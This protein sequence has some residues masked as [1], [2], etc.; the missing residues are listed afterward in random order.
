MLADHYFMKLRKIVNLSISEFVKTIKINKA[1]VLLIK[2]N[3]TVS[4]IAYK[5]GYNDVSYFSK[6]FKEVKGKSPTSFRNDY[7]G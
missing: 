5:T 6:V 7:E 4:E 1:S 3:F 2:T